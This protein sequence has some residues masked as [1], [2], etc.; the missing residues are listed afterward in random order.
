MKKRLSEDATILLFSAGLFGASL[1]VGLVV[2]Y[3]FDK[4]F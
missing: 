4:I 3:G 2:L 1:V